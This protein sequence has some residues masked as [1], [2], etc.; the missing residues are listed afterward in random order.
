[1]ESADFFY[2]FSVFA[3]LACM[4]MEWYY[5]E[6]SAIK[7][8]KKQIEMLEAFVTADQEY[9][10][11]LK[12]KILEMQDTFE[13]IKRSGTVFFKDEKRWQYKPVFDF[14]DKTVIIDY[15]LQEV[16]TTVSSPHTKSM[17]N[18]EQL[19]EVNQKQ[20]KAAVDAFKK[21]ISQYKIAQDTTLPKQDKD[22]IKKTLATTVRKP[23]IYKETAKTKKK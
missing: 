13:C 17:P 7:P 16:T 22:F 20:G 3:V 6:S 21:V 1:M 23:K 11:E 19:Y 5:I 8:L 4:V 14:K 18:E 9:I 15:K 2:F 10:Y 12:D